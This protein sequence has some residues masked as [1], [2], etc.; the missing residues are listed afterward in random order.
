MPVPKRRRSKSQK[1]MRHAVWKF[2][3]PN[4]SPCKHCGF[5]IRSHFACSQCGHYGDKL[6]VEPKKKAKQQKDS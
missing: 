1:R 4:L 2:E 5:M 6:V 3:L